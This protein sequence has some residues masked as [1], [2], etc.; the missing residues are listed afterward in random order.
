MTEALFWDGDSSAAAPQ[1]R[2]MAETADGPLARSPR[3]AAEHWRDICGVEQWRLA[4]G[5]L[6]SDRSAIRRLR[7]AIPRGVSVHD[8]ARAVADAQACAALLEAWWA[9][10]T[11]SPDAARLVNHI[12]SLSRKGWAETWNL[13]TAHLL[14]AQGDLP[15]AL[16]AARRRSFEMYPR[17]LPTFLREEGRLAALTGDTAGAITAYRHYLALRWDP[18]PSIKP[19]VE[20]V[21][22]EL[23]ALVA[24]QR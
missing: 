16:A 8:S 19:Q 6:G 3:G 22:A 24:E 11:R 12:D 5:A 15:R 18:E 13:V 2:D 7:A 17:F 23:A 4:H 14:E 1:F 20:Q 9:S 10:A 21:R